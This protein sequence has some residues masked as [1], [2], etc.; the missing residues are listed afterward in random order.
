[1]SLLRNE[2]T[3]H[4]RPRPS[5]WS[6]LLLAQACS[7][8]YGP[9]IPDGAVDQERDASAGE[10]AAAGPAGLPPDPAVPM[11]GPD[12]EMTLAPEIENA[13]FCPADKNLEGCSC[14]D[15]GKQAPCWPGKRA[16]RNRGICTDGMTTC[17]DIFEFGPAWGPCEGY[18]LPEEGAESGPGSCGCFANGRWAL[19]NVVPCIF[20][21]ERG[22][23]MFSSRPDGEDGYLCDPVAE[24]PPGAP[25]ESWSQGT[26]N[27]DCAGQFELCYVLKAGDVDDPSPEDC[28]VM[29]TCVEVWYEKAGQTQPLPDL[30]GWTAKDQACSKRFVDQGGY[31]EMT[32]QGIT[33]ECD[34]IDDG[35]G[36]PYVFRRSAYCSSKCVDTPDAEECASCSVMGTGEF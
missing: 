9:S 1:M 18:V 7:G 33:I 35:D 16:N 30:P 32:V 25:D 20:A 21:D 36:E 12:G 5:L 29:R 6:L 24:V 8:A 2:R 31:G 34:P 4:R 14:P 23:Y 26:L 3:A 28:L 11:C 15:V 10:A 13:K 19:S 17:M 27:V 22:T